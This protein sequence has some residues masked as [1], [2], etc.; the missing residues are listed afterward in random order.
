MV[1]AS[2]DKFLAKEHK[3]F[4]GGEWVAASDKAIFETL[5]PA[6]GTVLATVARAGSEDVDLAVAAARSAQKSSSWSLM[7]G[8]DRAEL[9]WRVADL[10]M[11]HA[12]ELALLETLDQGKPI[13]ATTVGDIPGTAATFRYMSGWANKLTGKTI[14]VGKPG[15]N[16]AYTVREPVGVVAQIVPWNF[17]LPMAAWKLAPALAAG[18][19]TILKPAEDTPLSTIRLFELMQQA[20]FPAGSINLL[21]GY[22]HDCGEALACHPGI[23]KIAFTGSTSVGKSIVVNSAS[24]L[25]KVSLELGGKNPSIVLKDADLDKAIPGIVQ[26][27]YGNAGQICTAP[28]RIFVHR[29]LLDRFSE[30]LLTSVSAIKLGPGV[31]Q[32][33]EMGPL[34]SAKQMKSVLA[35]IS[36][37]VAD[38]AYVLNGA[39]RYGDTGFFVEPTILA[40]TSNDMYINRKEVFGPVITLI[41]FDT[42]EEVIA[43]ANDSAFGLTAQVWTQ[44]IGSA[45]NFINQL[46]FGSIWLNGKSMDIALPFG[47][48]K[49][50][51]WGMEKGLEG[52]E[53]YT[54]T[55]TIVYSL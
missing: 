39:S 26:A 13:S 49:E 25:K 44:N 55:R 48:L 41:P 16:L 19:S 23:D 51:G 11:E 47:G 21:T 50:S 1:N 18:C 46:E 35:D 53:M 31:D 30:R 37:A 15:A 17:P 33:T 9:L 28:S 6:D 43:Q 54:R 45:N 32:S 20:G 34:I 14:P 4:I 12:D 5:N 42:E 40:Q 36:R 22:G 7:S 8:T 2:I 29:G 24:N 52:V 27:S 10:I 3:L 38:G